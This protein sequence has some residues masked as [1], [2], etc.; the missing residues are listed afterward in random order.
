MTYYCIDANQM[1]QENIIVSF[2]GHIIK[3][4]TWKYV[5]KCCDIARDEGLDNWMQTLSILESSYLG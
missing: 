1:P 5:Y 4:H 2:A 3:S